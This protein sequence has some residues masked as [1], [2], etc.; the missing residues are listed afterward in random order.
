MFVRFLSLFKPNTNTPITPSIQKPYQPQLDTIKLNALEERLKKC[1]YD[2]DKVPACFIDHISFN[3]ILEPRM[4]DNCPCHCVDNDTYALLES[5]NPFTNTPI[6][7]ITQGR[8]L[9][10][11]S[12]KNMIKF[13]ISSI[14][15]IQRLENEIAEIEKPIDLSFLGND[16]IIQDVEELDDL[17]RELKQ[18]QHDKA[19]EKKQ[20][21][22]V[23]LSEFIG[24]I[25][26]LIMNQAYEHDAKM[27]YATIMEPMQKKLDAIN[28][29]LKP[30]TPSPTIKRNGS[31]SMLELNQNT[32]SALR[33]LFPMSTFAA[34]QTKTSEKSVTLSKH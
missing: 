24:K 6:D 13:F 11:Q 21:L 3:I 1:G 18:E 9:Y 22:Q 19:I 2:P 33:L 14:E 15:S 27:E 23:I 17:E 7:E 20:I 31:F 10:Q 28:I 4:V 12:L 30:K 26:A 34:S 29:A 16:I 25:G 8:E 5:I 32:M